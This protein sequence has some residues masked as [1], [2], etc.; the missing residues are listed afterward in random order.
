MQP[1]PIDNYTIIPYSIVVKQGDFMTKKAK[2]TEV[3]VKEANEVH[4][5]SMDT[6]I[7]HTLTVE[8]K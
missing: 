5:I 6:R 7:Q 3:F 2:T 8:Q 1:Q 4:I